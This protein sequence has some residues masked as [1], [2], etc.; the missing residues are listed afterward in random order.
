V[1]RG[2]N[3]ATLVLERIDKKWPT[4]EAAT[5]SWTYRRPLLGMVALF[6]IG[7]SEPSLP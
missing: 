4:V 1:G 2:I 6:Q 7:T 3:E 5:A